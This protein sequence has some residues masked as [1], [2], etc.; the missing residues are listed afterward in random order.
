MLTPIFATDRFVD[1]SCLS[2]PVWGLDPRTGLSSKR[3][4]YSDSLNS[5]AAEF[6]ERVPDE[7]DDNGVAK[8]VIKEIAYM[9]RIKNKEM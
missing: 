7:R 4:T 3:T 9:T 8:F 6:L 2:W 5:L 1:L